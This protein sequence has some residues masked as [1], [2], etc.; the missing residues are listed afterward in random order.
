METVNQTGFRIGS[1]LHYYLVWGPGCRSTIRGHAFIL[2]GKYE[3]D[4]FA[5]INHWD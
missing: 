2:H 5:L 3:L 1:F 4:L